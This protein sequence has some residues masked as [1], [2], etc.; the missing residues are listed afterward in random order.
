MA[1]QGGWGGKS[2]PGGRSDSAHPHVSDILE[3]VPSKTRVKYTDAAKHTTE[4][5][6][7]L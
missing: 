3:I 5:P 6:L 1:V 7:A 2:I 4:T